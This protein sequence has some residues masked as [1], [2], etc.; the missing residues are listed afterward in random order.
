MARPKRGR[1][2]GKADKGKA[3][4]RDAGSDNDDEYQP[5]QAFLSRKEEQDYELALKLYSTMRNRILL[6]KSILAENQ[7]YSVILI[8]CVPQ[9]SRRRRSF[10]WLPRRR[11]DLGARESSL[12]PTPQELN[13]KPDQASNEEIHMRVLLGLVRSPLLHDAKVVWA[14]KFKLGP[15][16]SRIPARRVLHFLRSLHHGIEFFSG[17]TLRLCNKPSRAGKVPN[18]WVLGEVCWLGR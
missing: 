17:N 5:G 9:V 15:L 4:L 11:W 8:F 12:G 13:L 7:L 14:G 1:P 6:Y 3:R 18:V 2:K 16:R 10:L